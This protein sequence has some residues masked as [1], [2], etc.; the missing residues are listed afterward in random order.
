MADLRAIVSEVEDAMTS[1]LPTALPRSSYIAPSALPTTSSFQFGVATSPPSD[2]NIIKFTPKLRVPFFRGA[3]KTVFSDDMSSGPPNEPNLSPVSTAKLS[4]HMVVALPVMVALSTPVPGNPF[5][6]LAN[7]T[8]HN[9]AILVDSDQD[10]VHF[11]QS[12]KHVNSHIEEK[13]N[14]FWR[15]RFLSKFEKPRNY[16]AKKWDNLEYKRQYQ[17]RRSALKNGA[18]FKNGKTV[19]EKVCLQVLRDLINDS[20]SQQKFFEKKYPEIVYEDG[21]LVAIVRFCQNENILRSLLDPRNAPKRSS[22]GNKHTTDPLLQTIQ[23][24][25][26]PLLLADIGADVSVFPSSQISAYTPAI[27]QPIFQ[28]C[29]GGSINMEWTIHQI[30]FWKYHFTREAESTLF[31]D[32]SELEG[33]DFPKLWNSQLSQTGD[34]V[35]GE[36]WKQISAFLSP[37]EI[38]TIRGDDPPDDIQDEFTGAD[39][40]GAIQD[41]VIKMSPHDN[42]S[43]GNTAMIKHI[44]NAHRPSKRAKTRSDPKDDAPDAKPNTFRIKHPRGADGQWIAD[45]WIESLPSQSSISGWQRLSMTKF[46]VDTSGE[47]DYE[48]MW[49][50]EGVV[51]P[52]G[53]LIVGRWWSPN[54][55]ANTEKQYSGPFIMWNT[56]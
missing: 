49:A 26:S 22:I 44:L 39:S 30:N 25:L 8:I 48:T 32:I 42:T 28:G 2:P 20:F 46:W 41:L 40:G 18:L 14:S 21:N 29:N 16:Q 27:T 23:A 34:P 24:V 4:T 51:L 7:E 45:G 10:L 12:C 11:S 54:E 43:A 17:H 9:I 3:V 19:P 36:N 35:L 33:A 15:A 6:L 47:I 31:T 5:E 55:S 1:T 13:V 56:D 37:D 53:R 50:Y 52:G 38:Y